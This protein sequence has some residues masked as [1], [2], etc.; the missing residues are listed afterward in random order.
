MK[1]INANEIWQSEGRA[2]FKKKG[3]YN[4]GRRNLQD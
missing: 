2:L 4:N 3:E 1:I